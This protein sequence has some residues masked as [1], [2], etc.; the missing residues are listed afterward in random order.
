MNMNRTNPWTGFVVGDT[1]QRPDLVS[2]QVLCSP[3]E[4]TFEI[5]GSLIDA[6]HHAWPDATIEL[7]RYAPY[8]S[9]LKVNGEII[10]IKRKQGKIEH[11]GNIE[12]MG[13]GEVRIRHRQRFQGSYNTAPVFTRQGCRWTWLLTEVAAERFLLIHRSRIPQDW[14]ES[15]DEE[16][17]WQL[18]L[19]EMQ[20]DLEITIPVR[21]TAEQMRTL[22]QR[23]Q[24]LLN[25]DHTSLSVLPPPN[26]RG[27]DLDGTVD[28]D[29]DD[30]DEEE[31]VSHLPA[32]CFDD[33]DPD[34][35]QDS[36][37]EDSSASSSDPILHQEVEADRLLRGCAQR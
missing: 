17:E 8:T 19:S 24:A 25:R 10:E 28:D 7:P 15:P 14:F 1:D 27:G 13:H 18:P 35:A 22:A 5:I 30:L 31:L 33:N 2:P 6:V 37:A 36:S 9:D 21:P 11:M 29:E 4:P 34:P 16:V 32:S 12:H 23:L 3:D 26:S 20:E